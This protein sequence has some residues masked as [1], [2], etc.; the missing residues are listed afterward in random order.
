MTSVTCP[1]CL[2]TTPV[3]AKAG[4]ARPV[5]LR[6]RAP[7]TVELLS[8]AGLTAEG[9]V[10][11]TAPAAHEVVPFTGVP[12]GSLIGFLV[13]VGV[14]LVAAVAVGYATAYLRQHL[15]FVL[16]FALFYGLILGGITGLG[17]RAG[18]YRRQEGAVAAGAIVGV[19]GAF[20]LHYFG[21][22]I[23]M[24]DMPAL[25]LISFWTYMDLR[26]TVGTSIG[27]IELGYKGTA[28]YWSLEALVVVIASAAAATW[29][30]KRPFCAEC[31]VWKE[32]KQLGAFKIDGP[33]AVSAITNGQPLEMVAT[34]TADDRV[35]ISLYRCP[36]CGDAAGLEADVSATRGKGEGA[37][38]MTAIVTYPAA[39][40]AD[41][42]Q[43]R[44][45]CEERGY[46]TK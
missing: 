34:A 21:Y 43:A 28:I 38:T 46:G 11:S 9:A 10:P 3:L 24:Q 15:W 7:I 19:T 16:V 29:P 4:D 6:C 13:A 37:A 12:G 25:G 45:T 44:R 31:N 39:A 41:F 26:C 30:V 23:A 36:R 22:R 17:V 33:Q 8:P 27:S 20:L 32:K 40:A 14:G 18:K 42:E 5:C 35:V 1:A 2:H